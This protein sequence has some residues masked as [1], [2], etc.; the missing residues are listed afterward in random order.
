MAF[1]KAKHPEHK[2]P[3][4]TCNDKKKI[5]RLTGKKDA[6]GSPTTET[7]RCPDC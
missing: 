1:P 7:V 4:G 5:T 6:S 3:C 2:R